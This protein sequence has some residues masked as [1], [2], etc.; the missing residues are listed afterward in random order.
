[1]KRKGAIFISMIMLLVVYLAACAIVF[2][3]FHFFK[4]HI[5]KTVLDEYRWNKIQEIPLALFSMDMDGESFVSR[6]N[7]VYYLGSNNEKNQLKEKIDDT[8][9]NQLFYYFEETEYPFRVMIKV[10]GIEVITKYVEACE[11]EER[12]CTT[13]S[14]P[15]PP[16]KECH[17]YCSAECPSYSA[18]KKL[19]TSKV[20]EG[21]CT[22]HYD[23]SDC[24]VR[25]PVVY[26]AKF[27]F[28]LT[29]DGTDKF[30][31]ELSYKIEETQ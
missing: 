1:M 9:S 25:K 22:I 18:N 27:P 29:F 2:I 14:P 13:K 8:I 31:D 5:I 4:Y 12:D 23:I 17:C 16:G 7:R 30:V 20:D 10:D 21:R 3:F 11:I 28:P 6:V 26:S 19:T 15:V 24:V